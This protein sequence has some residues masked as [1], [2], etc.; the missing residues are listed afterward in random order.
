MTAER[1]IFALRN[2][3]GPRSEELDRNGV[4][5]ECDAPQPGKRFLRGDA[6]AGGSID[7]TDPVFILSFLFLGRVRELD[8]F[9]AADADDS[10]GL[11]L[12]D[13]VFILDYP[14][15]GGLAPAP[16]GPR[17]GRDPTEDAFPDCVTSGCRR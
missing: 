1:G 11:S 13:A 10:G 6:D 15:L 7:I 8:C 2:Q 4:P 12:T 5:D 9:D 17:C 3:W 16:P 14:F